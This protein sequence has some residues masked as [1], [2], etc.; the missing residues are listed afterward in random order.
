MYSAKRRLQRGGCMSIYAPNRVRYP[1]RSHTPKSRAR[2]NEC[3]TY[4]RAAL[5]QN[6]ANGRCRIRGW[7][8][9][10]AGFAKL[11]TA[12]R[13]DAT[14]G[15]RAPTVDALKG[16]RVRNYGPVGPLTQRFNGPI[17]AYD[18]LPIRLFFTP[19][20]MGSSAP[21]AK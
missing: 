6:R 15:H 8:P 20:A 9:D 12:V 1:K 3:R 11:R 16:G 4:G 18:V 7:R 17:F 2:G 5:Y 21:S 13:D 14:R 10:L 19:I